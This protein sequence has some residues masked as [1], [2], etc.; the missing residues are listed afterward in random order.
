MVLLL[1]QDLILHSPVL[2]AKR[3]KTRS[4]HLGS[5]HRDE[6]AGFT[7]KFLFFACSVPSEVKRAVITTVE[8]L[9]KDTFGT[10]CFCPL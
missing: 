5:D 2:Q 9:N 4:A 1:L 8:P 3:E 6:Y 10:S 7:R